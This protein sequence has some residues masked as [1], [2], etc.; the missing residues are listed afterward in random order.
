MNSN[1]ISSGQKAEEDSERNMNHKRKDSDLHLHVQP[2]SA[3]APAPAN[4]EPTSIIS[5]SSINHSTS[6]SR[7]SQQGKKEPLLGKDSRRVVCE[8]GSLPGCCLIRCDSLASLPHSQR[9]SSKQLL[10]P[11]W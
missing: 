10:Q 5:P 3:L 8:E 9:T 2:W 7:C 6:L 4:V 1:N 11:R